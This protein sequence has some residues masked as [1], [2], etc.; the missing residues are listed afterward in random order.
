MNT[1]IPPLPDGS[2]SLGGA[3]VGVFITETVV[4][5]VSVVVELVALLTA[6]FVDAADVVDDS[7]FIVDV[8]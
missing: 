4:L 7:T 1:D 5:A 8:I 3:F 2:M 6:V